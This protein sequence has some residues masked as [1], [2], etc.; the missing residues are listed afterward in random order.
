MKRKMLFE[1]WFKRTATPKR[2]VRTNRFAIMHRISQRYAEMPKASVICQSPNHVFYVMERQYFNSTPPP[3]LSISNTD[4]RQR[5]IRA[6]YFSG[7]N[8]ISNAQV[9]HQAALQPHPQH[10][11]ESSAFTLMKAHGY[12][13]PAA[14]ATAEATAAAGLRKTSLR[15]TE[16]MLEMCTLLG[17]IAAFKWDASPPGFWC[18]EHPSTLDL[19]DELTGNAKIRRVFHVS[20]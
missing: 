2:A 17:G 6:K 19:S 8:G 4:P 20:L 15:N 13:W 11:H 5:G 10:Q 3:P 9:K 12:Y 14:A 7:G 16:L 1:W 18:R